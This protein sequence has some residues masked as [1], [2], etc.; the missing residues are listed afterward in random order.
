ML[1]RAL[2]SS[3]EEDLGSKKSDG[4]GD[5][6]KNS[7]DRTVESD[8][9]PNCESNVDVNESKSQSQDRLVNAIIRAVELKASQQKELLSPPE[10][11]SKAF[12]STDEFCSH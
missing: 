9:S 12:D 5:D 3:S 4:I 11:G 10:I 2:H 6:E 7:S 1:Q 8:E